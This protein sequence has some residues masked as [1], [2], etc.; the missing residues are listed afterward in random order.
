[1]VWLPGADWSAQ[2]RLTG[3]TSGEHYAATQAQRR[4]ESEV[5]AIKREVAFG[6]EAGADMTAA[7]VRLG[8][9]QG[10]L[11]AHCESNH[12]RRDY[13][14]ERA[15]GLPSGSQPRALKAYALGRSERLI[16]R[17][18]KAKGTAY[19]VSRKAVNGKAYRAK[20]DSAGLPK[21][22][23]AACYSEAREILRDRDGTDGERMSVVA[24]RT[25]RKVCDT[26]GAAVASGRCSLTAEQG[27][28]VVSTEGGVVLLHNHPAST[29][30][31]WEDLRIVAAN[32]FVKAS[33]VLCHDGT[34]YAVS[35][36]SAELVEAYDDILMG[37]N[38]ELC[39]ELP[40]EQIKNAGA[41]RALQAKRGREVAED[42][43]TLTLWDFYEADEELRGGFMMIDD[44]PGA[45]F[46]YVLKD[47]EGDEREAFF[48]SLP[49]EFV[50][51]FDLSLLPKSGA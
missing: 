20:F 11:K 13:E 6:E 14:R 46:Y 42:K 23:A 12:L 25:G 2:E 47:L 37:L 41:R 17:E 48:E 16:P 7:R 51:G 4:L 30:P 19:D 44:R 33:L 43:K 15:Y 24:W 27:E 9:L 34:V 38:D 3:M 21:K 22:A 10:R 5:R 18:Q 49:K 29:R 36:T 31:S 8:K 50:A 35:G 45:S 32:D 39:G 26:F 40:D 1:M 28:R